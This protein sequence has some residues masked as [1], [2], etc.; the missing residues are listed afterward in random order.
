MFSIMFSIGLLVVVVIA[1][2]GRKPEVSIT[3]VSFFT[4][5]FFTFLGWYPVWIGSV[6]A[7]IIAL[8]LA[9]I[10]SGGF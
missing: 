3:F 6:M 1:T 2:K 10:I 5:V 7:L 4:T 9:K 8:L